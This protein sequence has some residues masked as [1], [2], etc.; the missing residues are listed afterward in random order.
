LH[1]HVFLDHDH[2]DILDH[3]HVDILDLG[4]SPGSM[5]SR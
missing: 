3:D 5:A 2:V 1:K 4:S